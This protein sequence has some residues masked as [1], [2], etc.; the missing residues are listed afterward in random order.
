MVS[1][2]RLFRDDLTKY[3]NFFDLE[4][5]ISV[6]LQNRTA[7]GVVNYG[8]FLRVYLKGQ[9]TGLISLGSTV[10]IIIYI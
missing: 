9:S 10:S 1:R 4:L 3:Y 8:L 6:L 2:I 5:N 7:F